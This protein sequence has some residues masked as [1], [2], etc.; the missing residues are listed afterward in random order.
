MRAKGLDEVVHHQTHQSSSFS[1]KCFSQPVCERSIHVSRHFMQSASTTEGEEPRIS[2]NYGSG[3]GIMP[4]A[5]EVDNRAVAIHH[6]CPHGDDRRQSGGGKWPR[7]RFGS[8]QSSASILLRSTAE[9]VVETIDLDDHLRKNCGAVNCVH[10]IGNICTDILL[11]PEL[12]LDLFSN[13]GK[14]MSFKLFNR[15]IALLSWP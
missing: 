15:L 3:N 14:R 6:R 4:T 8:R 9:E 11:Q 13:K 10:K 5:T 7:H 1:M 12:Y 2:E